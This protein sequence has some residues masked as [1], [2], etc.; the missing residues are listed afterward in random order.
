MSTAEAYVLGHSE[1]ELERLAAQAELVDP[2]TRRFFEA[3]GI[4][5]GMRV[6]DV[7]SGAGHTAVLLAHL[8]GPA[9]EVVGADPAGAAIET[10]TRR[11]AAAG[12]ANV[13]FRHGDPVE[14]ELG[15]PFD[16]IAGRYV[17]MFMPDPAR[18]LARLADRLRPGG[19]AGFHE[20][21]WGG[22]RALPPVPDYD[23]AV[24]D[25]R[26]ALVGGGACD[27]LGLRLAAT[28]AEAGLPQPTL[29]L[30]MTIGAG[31]TAAAVVRLVTDLAATLRP[32]M[33][34]LGIDAAADPPFAEVADRILAKLGPQGTIVG[35]SEVGAWCNV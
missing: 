16:V 10:A 24:S 33:E 11:V 25:I 35:R 6:L 28:F 5:P 3:A 14:L 13:S 4:G 9:G 1:R 12:L 22:C 18:T 17:L 15:Q 21:D 7:G 8:V 30:E 32:D 26:R 19:T 2:I 29:R 34:R 27:D 23:Q 31:A 20:P